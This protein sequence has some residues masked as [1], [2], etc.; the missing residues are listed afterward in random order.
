MDTTTKFLITKR[1]AAESLGLSIRALE[2]LLA[3]KLLPSI[4]I[5]RR[6][7]LPLSAVR[8]FAL[9]DHPGRI[10]PPTREGE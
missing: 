7:L 6:V 8:R 3:Q 10:S 2:Y 1:A 9:S 4:R 5:G